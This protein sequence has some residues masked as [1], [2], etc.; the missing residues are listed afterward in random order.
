MHPHTTERFSFPGIWVFLVIWFG[1]LV[2]LIG[3]RL[4]GFA[5][6]V[7]V[8]QQTG[9][10]TQFALITVC[11]SLPGVLM[12]PIAGALIDR[13]D[14]R[15]AM[16]LSDT[17][18]GL[19]TL[20]LIFLLL[21][22]QLQIWHI[23]LIMAVSSSF[24]AFQ[25]PAYAAATTLLVPKEHYGRVSGMLPLARSIAQ[26]LAPFAGGLLLL[27]M[28]LPG[29]L[30]IDVLTFLFSI[31][32][33]LLIRIPMPP[34]TQE[35]A[36]GDGSLLREAA[37]GWTYIMARPGLLRLLL[38]FTAHNVMV[39]IVTV[40]P[41]PLI[42]SFASVDVLGTVLAVS[43]AGM[44][45]G[46]VAMS[47]WGGPKRYMYGIYVAC[48]VRGVCILLAGVGPSAVLFAVSHSLSLFTL[49][50]MNGCSQAIWQ[51]KVAP[52]VQGRVF[53]IRK[54][55]A[56]SSLPLAHFVAGPLADD[57]FEPLLLAGGPLAGSVGR[58]IGVGPGRGIGLM[59]VLSGALLAVKTVVGMLS[60]RLRRVE[61]EL[62]DFNV[63]R[64]NKDEG[65]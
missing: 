51:R 8:Y 63:S 38:Y 21:T 33:L 42:L 39:G 54:M 34:K 57:V 19:C 31:I 10:T 28:G 5:L 9:S 16:V 15:L 12:L 47:V 20:T 43:G 4:T 40:L 36:A 64:E 55:I 29:V 7:W 30:L 14:R 61:E 52:D 65:T 44:L 3:T 60:P 22:E 59:F 53:A 37:Y 6:G 48:L 46:S 18:A 1:Q 26:T 17:G 2:S 25:W 24:D 50:I 32:S 11:T 45:L 13:W 41:T 49:P 58:I 35:G 27:T 56:F 62:P 23:Y